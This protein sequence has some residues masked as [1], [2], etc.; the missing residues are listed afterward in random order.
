VD[1]FGQDH[2]RIIRF[3]QG[4]W[5]PLLHG[6]L[7]GLLRAWAGDANGE[8]Y[9]QLVSGLAGTHT[10]AINRAFWRLGVVARESPELRDGLLAGEAAEALRARTASASFWPAFDA[11]LRTHGHRSESREVSD[12]RWSE[13][14][15]RVLI[16]VRAQ[17]RSAAP[18]RD[19]GELEAESQQRR[20][21]AEAR[22]GAAVSGGPLGALRRV[23]LRWVWRQTRLFTVYRENQRYHLDYL[24]AHVRQ[25]LLEIG[26]RLTA[27]GV[28]VE[29]FEVFLLE[30][31]EL[32]RQL[33]EPAPSAALRAAIAERSDHYRRW[34]DRLPATHLFDGIETE[35]EQAEGDPSQAPALQGDRV[36]LGASRGTAKARL[37]VVGDIASLDRIEPGEILVAENIDPAWTGVFPV[38]GG[39]ITETGGLLSHGAL[40]AREY[41]IPAVMGVP[42]ATTRFVTGMQAELDGTYG[43]VRVEPPE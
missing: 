33:A 14:P 4:Q 30:A 41:G 18:P 6:L 20:R 26:R 17:L 13:T 39:L 25:L 15:D 37:R 9:Q 35:G 43:S 3:G 38:L 5:N 19:P 22:A 2:F 31:A 16:F 42:Q 11:F 27:A 7:Q 24:L 32:E 10:A 29:P 23:L 8:L 28:L 1:R 40:L 36:G 12:P 34:K 21:E